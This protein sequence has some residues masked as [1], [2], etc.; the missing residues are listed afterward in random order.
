M[1]INKFI[2]ILWISLITFSLHAT[3]KQLLLGFVM[4]VKDEAHWVKEGLATIKDHIDYWCILDT[5]STDG[6]QELIK[7]ALKDIPGELH[8]EPFIDFAASRNR[9]LDLAGTKTE[10]VLTMNGDEFLHNGA[11]LRK[12]CQ[13]MHWRSEA[14]Y[15]IRRVDK[16]NS[17][18]SRR[19]I[20]TKAAPRFVGRTHEYLNNLSMIRVPN[21]FIFWDPPALDLERKKN[22]WKRDLKILTQD[23]EGD[24]TNTRTV[25][26]LAQTYDCLGNMKKA[27]EWYTLR[28]AMGGF[29]EEVYESLYR[30]GLLAKKMGK[31]DEEAMEL[32]RIAYK[33]S[34][35]RA[36][37]LYEIA[38][39]YRSMDQFNLA[40][41]YCRHACELPYPECDGL[42]VQKYIYDYARWDLMAITACY[43]NQFTLGQEAAARALA[44]DKNNEYLQKNFD[45]Y[46]NKLKPL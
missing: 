38:R 15:Q 35:H 42:F 44:Y 1:T 37:P 23:Y 11:D 45:Y 34:P 46:L 16:S 26:Y 6:T 14:S 33:H 30:K 12:F 31:S 27:F 10:F 29:Q 40:F 17:F 24:P 4:I 5:G 8:E 19:L 43:V 20:R 21:V 13:D 41:M 39:I 32:F 18:Y 9:V 2:L 36:E 25:F 28:A 22:A 3:Q 7:E